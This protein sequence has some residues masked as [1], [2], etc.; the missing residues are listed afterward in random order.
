MD[1]HRLDYS[2]VAIDRQDPCPETQLLEVGI[3]CS[4]G[5]RF[6]ASGNTFSEANGDVHRQYEQHVEARE[7]SV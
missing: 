2:S 6:F 1:Q 7:G 4:C 5:V 3:T